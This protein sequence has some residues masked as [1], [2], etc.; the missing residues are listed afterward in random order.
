MENGKKLFVGLDVGTDSVGWAATDEEY[1]LWRLKGKTAWGARL[2]SE[3]SNAKA[4]R[5]FRTSGR[6][7]AR[8]KERI[9]LLNTLFDPLLTKKDPTFLLRL[10]NSFYQNDDKQKDERAKTECPLFITK[11][12]EKEFYKQYPTIWH[13]RKA[14]MEN[15]DK[16]F[17]DIRYLYLAIH[18]IIKYRGNFLSS[19]EK[20]IG[21]FDESCLDS[22]NERL[23]SFFE[24]VSDAESFIGL[25][26]DNYEQFKSIILD[27]NMQRQYRKKNLIGLFS[28]SD[29]SKP[30]IEMFCSLSVG[31][32]FSTKS[33][34]P[35]DEE[36]IYD[37]TKII[38][39]GKYDEKEEEFKNVLG[40]A[41][42]FVEIAKAIYDFA[43]LNDILNGK[44]DLS[45]AFVELF[46]SHQYQL[47][48]LKKLC[49]QVDQAHGFSGEK[50]L[51]VQLFN[52]KNAKD[53]YAAYIH[54][55][56][57]QKRCTIEDF[58]K[59]VLS[60]FK[61]YGEELQQSLDWKQIKSL[62]EQTRLLQTIALRS[63]SV[64]PMQLH[65]KE[66]C[67]ILD[68]AC[69][70]NIDGI[71]DIKDKILSLF[72]YRIPYYCGPLTTKS[73]YSNVVF[74]GDR[75]EKI[76]PWNYKELV[77]FE[78]TK[79]KFMQG[80]T[81]KCTYLKDQDVLPKDSL[82][83]EEFDAL[84][85]LNN[86][87]INGER[88]KDM[89]ETLFSYAK[90]RVKTTMNDIKKY[91]IKTELA[92][93]EDISITGWNPNDFINC[94]SFAI[95]SKNGLFDLS[96]RYTKD[97][98][99][100]ERIIFLKAVFTDCPKDADSAIAKE[101]PNL[102]SEQKNAIKGLRCKGWSPLSE[103]F[104]TI[105]GTLVDNNGVVMGVSPAFI[106]LLLEGRG[107]LMQLYHDPRFGIKD[108]VDRHNHAI[109]EKKSK[110]EAVN[111]LIEEMPPQMRRPVIQAIRIVEEVAKVA[112][113]KNGPDVISIEVTRESNDS[114]TKKRKEK[115]ATSR[116]EQI[117]NF[118]KG[119]K[120]TDGHANDVLEELEKL[121][122]I[123]KLKGK[124]LYLYF[125]QNGKDAYSGEPI[126][127]NDVL[128]GTKYDTD[129]IIPQ[130]MMKDDSIDNLVLVKR[131][132]NQHR[133]N[134]YPLPIEIRN[135]RNKAF[136]RMLRKAKMMSDK[137]YN[138]LIRGTE[139]TEEELNDF[140]NA[141]INAV[142]RSNI[143]IRDALKIMYPDAKLIFS[144]A[145]YPSQ[146]RK[147]LEIPKLRDLN[148]THHA[149]DAYL[150][151]VSGVELTNRFGNMA[152]IKAM[153]NEPDKHSLNMER[154][155]SNLLWKDDGQ[156]AE[157]SELG[158]KIDAISR[159]HDFL[160]TCRFAY[161]DSAFYNQTI[162]GAKKGGGD[163]ALI[164]MH[165][166]LDTSKYGGYN[167]MSVECHCIATIQKKK[168]T[169]R[170][171]LGVPHLYLEMAKNG[172]DIGELLI[173]RVP[174]KEG[175]IV[176]V[177]LEHV[178]PL[179]SL[180]EKQGLEYLCTS[181]NSDQ[182]ML[183]PF[184]PLFLSRES[185]WYLSLLER[186]LEKDK[187]LSEKS[188][189][190]FSRNKD[191]TV[192]INLS[193]EL[194]LSVLNE[195]FELSKRPIYDYCDS[196]ITELRNEDVREK[197]RNEVLTG[198]LQTQ[199]DC[200]K[201]VIS[202]FTRKCKAIS[203]KYFSK[204]RGALLQDDLNLVS[205]SITGLYETSRKL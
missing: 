197:M 196:M 151:V 143:V 174:H 16:A 137:K 11:K 158:N 107:N 131:E 80:L 123:D 13:L 61:D 95:L 40:D 118:L 140:V 187:L 162:Y 205:K 106:D 145:K 36:P 12:E 64:I 89:V 195:V 92:K 31:L 20:K 188:S 77:N 112:K 120:K 201:S 53:N 66:L 116:R 74:N 165:E 191:E 170:Y 45:T 69:A 76:L 117:E 68:N 82:L 169:V 44:E 37:D 87:S 22:L 190:C 35:K 122:D 149:V 41:F 100:C 203:G 42:D 173:A 32:S 180:I 84:N 2:F 73:P 38:F 1:N 4:R 9:R 182:A 43:D 97:F 10:Q 75:H 47:R 110:K 63:T 139:L 168:K 189:I 29:E 153:K 163:D 71:A 30:F 50:S 126:N 103:A 144:K 17:S 198:T 91:L 8:R 24:N 56:T 39:D 98:K 121:D 101:F 172:K 6:R 99:M 104:L 70:R 133:K 193:P 60:L 135:E 136:W 18:H 167:S 159:K 78:E 88:Q 164:S 48:A 175:E 161:Q 58:N 202:R 181:K 109:F 199:C 19:D 128:H 204:S 171:L 124:H 194:S 155:I 178:I 14:L 94:S 192:F 67:E 130:S 72:E 157:K 62:A 132:T 46:E 111:E 3:A 166:S 65:Q 27:K 154:F 96:S 176:T 25:S 102:S 141:Q 146:I 113:R 49:H 23:K 79:Q 51:Y 119:L 59:K 138:N 129:H 186:T 114:K 54:R 57:T 83:Y 85:K 127:I 147:E 148:D 26:Q 55:G 34:N 125:L 200:L 52:D 142:N 105:K 28:S 184:T 185:E 134:Q 183:Y 160:L 179:Q 15:D 86:L 93:R 152:L 150:N 108:A 115:E 90:T 7:L 21:Q 177:D 156:N 81:N 33:L 5:G